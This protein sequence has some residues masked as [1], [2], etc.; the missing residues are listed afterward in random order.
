EGAIVVTYGD[1]HQIVQIT[2]PKGDARSTE[3]RELDGK[4]NTALLHVLRSRRKAYMT[5]G[6]G[7]L[8]DPL[9]NWGERVGSQV[10]QLENILGSLNY[11]AENFGLMEGLGHQVPEDADLVMMLAPRTPLAEEEMAALDAYLADGGKMLIV[12][13]PDTEVGL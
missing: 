8:N 1:K 9:G 7:E 6:H 11:D 10:A 4:I 12:L 3:L 13:D 5:V 2:I